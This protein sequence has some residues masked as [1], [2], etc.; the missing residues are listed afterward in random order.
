MKA[1]VVIVSI[2]FAVFAGL[3]MAIAG[4]AALILV[5]PLIVGT[6]IIRDYRVGVVIL[7]LIFPLFGSAL[8]PR[9]EG[10]NPYTYVTAL[11]ITALMLRK[12][13]GAGRIAWPPNMLWWCIA[14]PLIAAF[15]LGLPHLSEG[16]RNLRQI[17]PAAKMDELSYFKQSI[18]EPLLLV[19]FAFLLS[20]AIIDSKKPERFLVLFALSAMIVVLYVMAFTVSTGVAW[21]PHRWVISKAGMHYNGYGQLFALAFGPL[22]FMAFVGR[23]PWR[24]FFSLAALIIFVG[25]VFNFARAGMLAALITVGLFLWR[26]RSIGAAA[27]LV[28]LAVVVFLLAPDEWRSRMLQGSDEVATSY[29]GESYSQLTSGRL[30]GWLDLFPEVGSSPLYGR[31]ML[32]TLWSSA[33]TNGLYPSSH[34]HNMYLQL[35]MDVGI[36]GLALV[37]YFYYT[38]LRAMLTLSRDNGLEPRIRAFFAGAWASLVGNLILSITGWDWFPANEQSF[39]WFSIGMTFAY[40]SRATPVVVSTDKS[41][42]LFVRKRSLVSFLKEHDLNGLTNKNR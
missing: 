41:E 40:W 29:R 1:L 12:S 18:Y 17:N 14:L 33:V 10:L 7:V 6:M 35:L 19:I 37:L 4:E 15:L 9:A 5:V 30:Q 3:A 42:S 32:S 16:V 8:V 2:L 28:G 13:L 20:N 34:P 31:G 23:G 27:V 26:R 38:I 11:T 24:I 25:L 36:L 21:G 22:L 39:L